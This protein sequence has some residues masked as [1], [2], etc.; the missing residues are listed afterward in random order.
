M[1][2][3]ALLVLI[4]DQ[5]RPADTFVNHHMHVA[6]PSSL[7][8][9]FVDYNEVALL[10]VVWFACIAKGR[11]LVSHNAGVGEFGDRYFCD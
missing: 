2:L 9:C 3:Q 7:V 1:W 4:Q 11:G 10:A 5:G 6:C 8:V